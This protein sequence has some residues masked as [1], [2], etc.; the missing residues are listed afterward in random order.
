MASATSHLAENSN[1]T[2]RVVEDEQRSWALRSEAM[3]CRAHKIACENP[4]IDVGDIYHALQ[5]LDLTP[6]ERLRRG[7]SRGRLRI[8]AR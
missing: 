3:W 2:P 1:E 8:Y 6:T 5:C 7:L 4:A